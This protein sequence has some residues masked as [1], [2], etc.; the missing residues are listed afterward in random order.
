MLKNKEVKRWLLMSLV[1]VGI[2]TY[3]IYSISP[4]AALYTFCAE[5][6]LIG[7]YY[8]ETKQR[9]RKINQLSLHLM[10]MFAGKSA[11][12]ISDNQEGEL[13][14][15]KNDIYKITLMLREKTELLQKDKIYLADTLSDISHQLKTPLTAMFM[16]TDLLS[17]PQLPV[18][19]RVE[20]IEHIRQQLE[21]IEWLVGSLLKMSKIDAKAV[22][23]KKEPILMKDL[24]EQAL[25]PLLVPIDMKEVAIQFTGDDTIFWHGDKHWTVEALVNVLKNAIE[26][27]SQKG[28]V[29]I[30]CT[31]NPLHIELIIAD[32][33]EGIPAN[34]I[35][36][37]FERFYRGE[38]AKPDSVGIGLAMSKSILQHQQATIEVTSEIGKG[39]TFLIKFYLP[40]VSD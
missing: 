20:F 3:L 34:D 1:V 38:N 40:H 39:T 14:L 21:R 17:D 16:M 23:F 13:S 10:D 31:K 36:H 15:L 24:I 11:L 37:L 7:L 9:Y 27:V 2:S 29:S 6:V 32:D 18:A 22:V 26:H 5:G 28:H 35:P 30:Q 33:G 19:K 12:D 4:Q 25:N 8:M